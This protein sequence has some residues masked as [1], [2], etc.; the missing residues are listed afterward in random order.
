MYVRLSAC[1]RKPFLALL[2]AIAAAAFAVPS[3]LADRD[4]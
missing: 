3:A 4:R 1:L 2:A